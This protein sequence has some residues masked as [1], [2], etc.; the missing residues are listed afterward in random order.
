MTLPR[1]IELFYVPDATFVE[2]EIVQLTPGLIASGMGAAWWVETGVDPARC[3]REIDRYWDWTTLEIERDGRFLDGQKIG[4]LTGNGAVQGAALFSIEPVECVL[5]AGRPA[6]FVELLSRRHATDP[7]CASIRRSNFAALE[8]SCS[9][10]SRH[11][12]STADTQV[13]SNWIP[14]PILSI[15]ISDEVSRKLQNKLWLMRV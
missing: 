2:A 13:A 3:E 8:C 12:A 10:Q 4:V 6:L 5:D 15:G 9:P 14:A 7:G 1:L 11:R